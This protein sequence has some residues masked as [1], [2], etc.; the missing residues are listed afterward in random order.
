M[1]SAVIPRGTNCP[2]GPSGPCLQ[3]ALLH[4]LNPQQCAEH[5][6][7]A[8]NQGIHGGEDLWDSTEVMDPS[9][10]PSPRAC[11]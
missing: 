10:S 1:H 7:C 4:K 9:T 8:Q 11:T 3:V 2:L 6:S 5:L